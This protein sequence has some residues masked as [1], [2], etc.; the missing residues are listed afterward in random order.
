MAKGPCSAMQRFPCLPSCPCR[1][2][3]VL[4][5][6]SWTMA[7]MMVLPTWWCYQSPTSPC[8]ALKP[9]QQRKNDGS[10]SLVTL[11][12]GTEGPICRP[13]PLHSEGCYLPGAKDMRK[14]LPCLVR[15]P[16]YY[17]LLLFQ[18]GSND[19]GRNS[20]KPMKK[21]FRALG[22]QVKTL[23]AGVV[24]SSIPPVIG[25]D[26]GLNMMGQR[27]NTWL[28]AWCAW[29]GFGFFDLCS[30]CMRPDWLATDRSSF[31]HRRK[32]VLRQELGR[33]H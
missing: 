2:G 12:K 18:V 33:F 16:D 21:D 27:I 22:R 32:G 7:V 1:A 4:C 24:F 19:I 11:L 13:D 25:N 8:L 3:T 29:Q 30:V 9:H 28:R 10:L 15:P 20:L 6:D 31:S 23:G 5:G 26:D 14:K 17:P